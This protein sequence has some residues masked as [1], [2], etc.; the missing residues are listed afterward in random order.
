MGIVVYLIGIPFHSC[1]IKAI[2]QVL[3]GVITYSVIN[4]LIHNEVMMEV[5]Q[6]IRKQRVN[7][8]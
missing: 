5:F 6:I 4:Y 7:N 1:F 8:E 3:F 2:F